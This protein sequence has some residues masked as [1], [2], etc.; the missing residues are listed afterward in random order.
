MGKFARPQFGDYIMN[1]PKNTDDAQDIYVRA[2][3]VV[4]QNKEKHG[5]KAKFPSER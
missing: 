1:K 3:T 5:E 4:Q 2:H